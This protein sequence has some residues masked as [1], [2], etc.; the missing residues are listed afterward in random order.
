MSVA[1]L[2]FQQNSLSGSRSNANFLTLVVPV[3]RDLEDGTHVVCSEDQ[4]CQASLAGET[5]RAEPG[6][7]AGASLGAGGDD[8][9]PPGHSRENL[10]FT[11]LPLVYW[12]ILG[13]HTLL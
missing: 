10:P 7:A 12:V 9:S 1:E 2:R 13:T 6:A 5:A 8:S 11:A 4:R 3:D